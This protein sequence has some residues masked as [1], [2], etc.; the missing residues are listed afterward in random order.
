MI[1]L[2]VTGLKYHEF[3]IQ[4]YLKAND[5]SE[6]ESKIIF[7]AR[8]KTLDVKANFASSEEKLINEEKFYCKICEDKKEDNQEHLFLCKTLKVKIPELAD[9]PVNLS[10]IYSKDI[11]KLK[12]VSKLLSQLLKAR[13][14]LIK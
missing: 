11:S 14:E 13:N 4:P 2:K 12:Q 7:K 5:I 1:E 6:Q 8:T 9:T 10:D 3:Q